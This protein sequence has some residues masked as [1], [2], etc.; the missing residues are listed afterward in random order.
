MASGGSTTTTRL[1]STPR[2]ASTTRSTPTAGPRSRATN[3]IGR[4][5]PFELRQLEARL[6]I[7]ERRVAERV[8][9]VQATSQTLALIEA[10]RVVAVSAGRDLDATLAALARQARQLWETDLA[11]IE[12]APVSDPAS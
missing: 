9:R 3:K 4:P 12:L 5:K 7:A 1:S 6:T 8:A 2:W 11:A 10:T